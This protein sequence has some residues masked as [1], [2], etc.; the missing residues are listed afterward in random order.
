MADGT[1][2]AAAVAPGT[3]APAELAAGADPRGVGVGRE[4]SGSGVDGT[5]GAGAAMGPA[6]A[7]IKPASPMTSARRRCTL[8][9]LA[10]PPR[11][12]KLEERS[13]RRLWLGGANDRRAHAHA[14][15]A[16]R[17]QRGCPLR[18]D[19]P[20]H[21]QRQPGR[22]AH[23]SQQALTRGRTSVGFGRCRK[24]RPGRNVA[25]ALTRRQVRFGPRADRD[26]D[27]GRRSQQPSRI[28]GRQILLADV[29]DVRSV[30][31]GGQGHVDAV[32]DDEGHLGLLAN[33]LQVM[34]ELEQLEGGGLFGAQLDR[35]DSTAQG[36]GDDTRQLF[37]RHEPS[38][39]QE[40]EAQCCAETIG[41]P[42][43]H[44]GVGQKVSALARVK[45]APYNRGRVQDR[46]GISEASRLLQEGLQLLEVRSREVDAA[47][48]RAEDR[49]RQITE[50][51]RERALEIVAEAESQ[52]ASLEEQVAALRTEVAAARKELADLKA[53]PKETRSAAAH[54]ENRA[55]APEPIV[56]VPIPA[57]APA[58]AA[59][60]PVEAAPAESAPVEAAAAETAASADVVEPAGTPRWG[61]QSSSAAAQQ[62]I[63]ERGTRPRWLP[64]WLPFVIL[65]LA[66]A[67]L[68]AANVDAVGGGAR[69]L[70]GDTFSS[71]S[72]TPDV[73]V[74]SFA[75]TNVASPT[76]Q[77]ALTVATA[78]TIAT[79]IAAVAGSLPQLTATRAPA[80]TVSGAQASSTGPTATPRTTATVAATPQPAS[81]PPARAPLTP[82]VPPP[83]VLSPDGPIVAAYTA[84][85]NYIVKTGDTLNR[86]A[87]DFGVTGESI[88]HASGL[89]DPNLL[90]PGQLLTIPRDSGWL[91]RVQPNDTLE[92]IAARFGVSVQDLLTASM[93]SSPS[94]RPGDLLFIPNRATPAPK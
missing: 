69:T 33:G 41:I 3:G 28:V 19:P 66:A 90:Q 45:H 62:A 10:R 23:T 76:S 49:A 34:C 17:V 64:P 87:S 26:A 60:A 44:F 15:R 82:P 68:V 25:G 84:Y 61:R 6:Q 80:L 27:D 63:R 53:A 5:S 8:A 81:V 38:I 59:A 4:P 37:R 89:S 46:G 31:P 79:S 56:A 47:V 42:D 78:T 85:S 83:D 75:P 16:G 13:R 88:S 32:V 73:I 43:E 58:P 12:A 36:V 74:V 67:G 14:V 92:Q 29:P 30:G 48:R 18:R 77:P 20:N 50:E 40:V 9:S 7:V 65:V 70:V 71:A 54:K 1:S 55:A 52:R 94:V 86:V 35:G 11:A 24:H 21:H 72:P 57:V 22:R 2:G 93:L 91:Y 51:A 39:R